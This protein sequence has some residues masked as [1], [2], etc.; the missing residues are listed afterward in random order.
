MKFLDITV[1]HRKH[2]VCESSYFITFLSECVTSKDCPYGGL[3]YQCIDNF[4]KCPSPLFLDGDMCKGKL[5]FDTE[6]SQN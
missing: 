3:N 4:C 1:F 2:R 6:K 5:T